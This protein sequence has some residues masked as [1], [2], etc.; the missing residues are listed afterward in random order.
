MGIN[1]EHRALIRDM[2]GLNPPND[3]SY[4]GDAV[5]PSGVLGD[6]GAR[7]VVYATGD[8]AGGPDCA[9]SHPCQLVVIT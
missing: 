7:P 9:G 5:P 6:T 4:E 3:R 8:A 1:C 2:A